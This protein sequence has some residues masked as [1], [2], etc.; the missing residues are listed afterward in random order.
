LNVVAEGVESEAQRDVLVALGCDELQGYLFAKP[1]PP[2]VLALWASGEG[3]AAGSDF[4][5]SLFDPT[6]PAPLR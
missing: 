4:R 2:A 3:P 1:M 5:P 6:A